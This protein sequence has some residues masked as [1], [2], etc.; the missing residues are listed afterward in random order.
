MDAHFPKIPNMKGK[1][2]SDADSRI[3]S[4]ETAIRITSEG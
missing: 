3:V 2:G 1:N 4:F